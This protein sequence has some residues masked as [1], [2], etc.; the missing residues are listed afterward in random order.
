VLDAFEVAQFI[1]EN[2]LYHS[3]DFN[4]LSLKVSFRVCD[5]VTVDLET[6]EDA[7]EGDHGHHGGTGGG[8]D[9]EAGSRGGGDQESQM[10]GR[11]D[12]PSAVIS[13]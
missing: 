4:L 8:G 7:I 2:L 3:P 5:L 10:G 11:P 6:P 12:D 9:E 13:C 1:F